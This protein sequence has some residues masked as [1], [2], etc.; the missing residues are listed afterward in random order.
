[1]AKYP[2]RAQVIKS[3]ADAIYGGPILN[4]AHRGGVVEMM[5]LSAL[6][7]VGSDSILGN[8]PRR[9]S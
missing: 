2:T 1:M 6:G 8:P 9:E 5:V 4:N 3:V 7:R